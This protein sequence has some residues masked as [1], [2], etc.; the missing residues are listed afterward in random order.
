M[1][2]LYATNFIHIHCLH[3]LRPQ[4]YI[5]FV[6]KIIS[7]AKRKKNSSSQ[8]RCPDSSVPGDHVTS[9]HPLEHLGHKVSLCLVHSDLKSLAANDYLC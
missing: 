8:S 4:Y 2:I 9:K 1:A 5:L 6:Q 7:V 3:K